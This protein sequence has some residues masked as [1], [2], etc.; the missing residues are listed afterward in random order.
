MRK[1]ERG[2]AAL[3][4]IRA[5][6]RLTVYRAL[7]T[8][9]ITLASSEMFFVVNYSMMM[10]STTTER[11]I[12]YRFWFWQ[13]AHIVNKSGSIWLQHFSVYFSK[14][15]KILGVFLKYIWN[16]T[17]CSMLSSTNL[18]GGNPVDGLPLVWNMFSLFAEW[19][20]NSWIRNEDPTREK[21]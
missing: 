18:T 16:E 19:Y 11:E 9:F 4:V 12:D 10:K 14:T 1:I 13:W 6:T 3:P 8:N 21:W 2:A 17:C 7:P 20:G 5:G 15:L